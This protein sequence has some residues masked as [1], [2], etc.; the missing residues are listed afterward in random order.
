VIINSPLSGLVTGLESVPDQVFSGGLMGPG[1]AVMPAA[2]ATQAIAPVSG[3]IAKIHPH[4]FVIETETG[5]GVLV[6][7]GLNTV[8]L[9]GEGFTVHAADGQQVSQGDLLITWDPVVIREQGYE[10]I[11]PVIAMQ[12]DPQAVR[13]L[14]EP[15]Q[16]ISSGDP[17]LDWVV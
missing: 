8:Q 17:L 11:V 5:L 16:S 12:A 2:D 6:H 1:L 3:K 10:V 15:G 7:L 13:L 9:N 14:A 4:A